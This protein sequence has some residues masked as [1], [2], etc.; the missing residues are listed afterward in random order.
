MLDKS[1]VTD[2]TTERPTFADDKLLELLRAQKVDVRAKPLFTSTPAWLT[3]LANFGPTLLII[4]FVVLATPSMRSGARARWHRPAW[5]LQGG[6]RRHRIDPGHLIPLD[7]ALGVS[8]R[9]P[10]RRLV[11]GHRPRDRAPRC[12]PRQRVPR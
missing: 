11:R 3:L 2:F 5:S 9:R 12:R 10:M 4:G 7:H 6:A 1:P 8:S